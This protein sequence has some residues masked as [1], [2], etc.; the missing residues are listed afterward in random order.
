MFYY[1]NDKKLKTKLEKAKVFPLGEGI[2]VGVTSSILLK[3]KLPTIALFAETS[4][5]LPDSQAAANVI[6]TLDKLLGLK[7]DPKPL[8]DQAQKFEKK[9]KTLL[10]QAQHINKE[11]DKKQIGYIG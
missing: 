8:T 7:V 4:L 1:T 9:L 3:T 10:E 5:G 6:T 2:I 11:K